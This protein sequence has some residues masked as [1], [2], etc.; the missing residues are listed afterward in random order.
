MLGD[1]KKLDRELRAKQKR[2]ETERTEFEKERLDLLR[3]KRY[4]LKEHVR[5]GTAW[6]RHNNFKSQ[7][8]LPSHFYS[9]T[10]EH[11]NLCVVEG[12]DAFLIQSKLNH[13]VAR[14]SS[15]RHSGFGF[16]R[17]DQRKKSKHQ[18]REVFSDSGDGHRRSGDDGA[19]GDSCSH[20]LGMFVAIKRVGAR[21][22]VTAA[23]VRT[24]AR[25]GDSMPV[26]VKNS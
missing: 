25:G 16:C 17:T 5:I 7:I 24:A 15:A 22:M 4:L 19:S 3:E 14:I 11:Q 8:I 12:V 10:R 2:I 9:D 23:M 1:L 18:T 21:T 6:I 20:L 13:G 26:K